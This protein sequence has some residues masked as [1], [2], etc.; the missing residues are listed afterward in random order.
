MLARIT[1][2]RHT[3]T[4]AL[5]WLWLV[6]AMASSGVAAEP[7]ASGAL[8]LRI[9][10]VGN[11]YTYVN[12][13]PAILQQLAV[14][15]G[16]PKPLVASSTPGGYKL[17]Q[18]VLHEPTLKKIADGPGDN[19]RWDVVVVQEH[20][21]VPA[22]AEEQADQREAFLNS[23]VGLYQKIK[24]HN[25]A[26]RVVLYE[27]WARQAGLWQKSAAEMR[28][29]GTD[30]GQMQDRLQKWYEMAAQKM[31]A[32]GGPEGAKSLAIARVGEA[33]GRN[34]RTA[35][36]LPLHAADGSH[37]SFSG[38]YL[39]GLVLF[40]T[41]YQIAPDKVT[42]VGK[43]Q[44]SEAATLKALATAPPAPQRVRVESSIFG[45]LPDGAQVERYTLTNAHG[46][47]VQLMTYGA[48]LTSV[49]VPDRHG[50]F[51]NVNLYLD[52]FDDYYRGHPLFGSIVGRYAGRIAGAKFTLDGIEY[53]LEPNAGKYHIHGGKLGFYKQLWQ[54]QASTDEASASVELTH[55]SPDGQAGYPGTLSVKVRYQLTNADELRIEYTAQTD[56][57]TIVNLTNHAY[58]NLAGAGSGDVLS[59][60][61]QLNAD[62]YV[63]CD[64]ANL[65]TGELRPVEG[66]VMD[67]RKPAPIAARIPQVQ[68]ENYDHCY[69]LNKQPGDKMSLAARVFEP[70]SGRVLEVYTTQP[71][72]Q[73]FTAKPLA[74]HWQAGGV[75][76]G[77]YH[78][79]C[80]ETQHYP[81]SPNRPAFPTTV[82]RPGQTFRE[83]TV[84]KFS[85]RSAP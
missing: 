79:F 67:L 20:S 21:Q 51:A 65:P 69:V 83:T 13:L 85:V 52:T 84:F 29:L 33:W 31:A 72:V 9:L 41:I 1:N 76:Y 75:P 54:A 39:A 14:S 17:S 15:A 6:W 74:N 61:Y 12:D 42:F 22:L 32:A 73:F 66:S 57:P 62:R 28:R 58:W 8:P 43:L 59:H 18:H 82:L 26:A 7:L 35:Q 81:D 34:F 2:R 80:F 40:S 71:G 56:K 70:R 60:E 3:P 24:E 27:T 16:Q 19:L 10:F 30:P 78:G 53:K 11:S 47:E 38:S 63:V 77:S 49:K 4:S 45:R 25:P 44:E 5:T 48:T 37:P 55:V 68:F 23:A 36:P 64:D 46:M 50:K